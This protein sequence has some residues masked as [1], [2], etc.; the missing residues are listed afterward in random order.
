VLLVGLFIGYK[1]LATDRNL[2]AAI[3]A[4]A[5]VP[6]AIVA[7]QWIRL[8]RALGTATLQMNEDVVPM[9]WNGT[10]T[11]VR[12]LHGATIREVEARLQCE[13]FVER[14]GAKR[15]HQWRRVVVNETLPVQAAPMMEQ[16]RITIPIKVP[17]S[18]PPTLYVRD[19]EINWWVRLHLKM[20]G[21]PNTR[22]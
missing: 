15:R 17:M 4:G 16:M 14:R 1:L 12:P 9:G 2:G 6:A 11:Y 18:G 22:S 10:A 3:I 13:E 5:V 20:D 7:W 21:C 8:R 19:N